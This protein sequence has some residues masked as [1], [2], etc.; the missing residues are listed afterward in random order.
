MNK[1]ADVAVVIVTYNSENEISTCLESVAAETQDAALQLVVVD[2]GS[3]DGT[4]RLVREKFPEVKLI[5]PGSN[6]GFA[7]GVN[8][9]V[10]NSDAEFVLLL[11]PDAE[12]RKNSIDKVLAFARSNP[13]YGLYGG[14]SYDSTGEVDPS[15]CWGAP[16]L[17]SLFLFASG[18][19]T[20]FPRSDLF[21]PESL[22]SWKRDTVREVGII[23]GCFLLAPRAVWDELGGLDERFF[24]YGEDADLAMRA[25]A[26]GYAPVICPDA[27]FIHEGGKSSDTP[28]SKTLLLFK[29]K[30]TLVRFH[31]RGLGRSLGLLFLAAGTGLR[32][33]LARLSSG[34]SADRWPTVWE[35]RN[36]WLPGYPV[37]GNPTEKGA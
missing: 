14:R 22:G 34:G 2:N 25:R 26:A 37:T 5:E 17:W 6:L 11:N 16:T 30:A 29:G 28:A 9:G 7:A 32:A 33:L 24:M 31:W 15:S 21:D 23:T 35:K 8:F 4:V 18:L 3:K 10:K 27:G 36:Q 12:V 20:V 1:Q 19:T 13:R